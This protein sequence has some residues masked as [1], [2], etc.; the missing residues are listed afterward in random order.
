MVDDDRILRETL[1]E[2]VSDC[3]YH[4]LE[5][6]DGRTGLQLFSH[7]TIHLV[8]SDVDMPDMSGFEL[9][10]RLHQAEFNRPVILASAR[11]DEVMELAAQQAGAYC[12][13][14]KPI[15]VAAFCRTLTELSNQ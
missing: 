12:L 3:G 11:A 10:A 14:A 2:L 9:L 15:P 6:A 7:H 4:G 8:V 5:A 13:F 1:L